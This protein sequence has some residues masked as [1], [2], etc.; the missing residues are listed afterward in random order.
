M[1]RIR[2]MSRGDLAAVVQ[3]HKGAFSG[4]FLEQMGAPFL[5]QYY[6]TVLAYQPNLS[7]VAVD[8]SGKV[9]GF[10]AGF[11]N[12]TAFYAHLRRRRIR[13]VPAIILA[14]LRRPGLL[15]GILNNSRRVSTGGVQEARTGELA[16]IGVHAAG[17]GVGSK[18][19]ETF[20][21]RMFSKGADRIALT[22]DDDGNESVQN[23][24][25]RRGFRN[26]VEERRGARLLRRYELTAPALPQ[27][28]FR[29]S[30]CH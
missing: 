15:Q 6:A 21:L 26:V 23:F 20:C 2:L 1:V 9:V 11:L 12:P 29:P 30:G 17:S 3:V 28:E 16:S 25:E 24:Y 8:E 22:T 5:R 13:F 27:V 14:L 4:F 7:L 19:L 10:A 18:L